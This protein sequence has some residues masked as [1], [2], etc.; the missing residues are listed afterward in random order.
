M[1]K[2]IFFISIFLSFY[3]HTISASA[4]RISAEELNKVVVNED[5]IILDARS[6]NDYDVGH[7]KKCN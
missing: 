3:S 6:K 1:F 4:F 5:V 2:L 7:I